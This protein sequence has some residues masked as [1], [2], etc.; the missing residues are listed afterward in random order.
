MSTDWIERYVY[1]IGRE[2]SEPQ[3]TD[4]E[5]E[6]R[7]LIADMLD[8]RLDGRAASDEDVQAVLTELGNPSLLADRYRD[9]KRYLIGPQLYASYLNILKIVAGAISISMVVLFVIQILT[10]PDAILKSFVSTLSTWFSALFQGFAWVTIGFAATERMKPSVTGIDLQDGED[11]KLRDLPELPETKN[12]IPRA[13]PIWG[14]TFLAIFA[15]IV[16]FGP[17][18]LG[19]W[20]I[21]AGKPFALVPFFDIA[22]FKS[23][24]PYIWA[25]ILIDLGLEIAKYYYGRWTIRLSIAELANNLIHLAI[26]VFMFSNPLLWNQNFLAG[27]VQNRLFGI[28][29]D[30]YLSQQL[31]WNWVTTYIV[32]L[33]VMAYGLNLILNGIKIFKMI[34]RTD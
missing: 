24:L 25:S 5:K 9:R 21:D 14:I 1:A 34:R 23:Y 12:R 17:H 16:T 15:I 11:W 4:I 10:A 30:P 20:F 31:V 32:Y 7:G 22:V 29:S 27:L 6:I 33:I 8:S 13:E 18:L 19:I 2:F 3:R 28:G 26:G